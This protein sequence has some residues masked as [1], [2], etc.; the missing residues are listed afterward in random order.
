M[1]RR[2]L[3]T[4]QEEEEDAGDTLSASAAAVPT[5]PTALPTSVVTGAPTAGP[6]AP[7]IPDGSTEI[8]AA[9][10]DGA[11]DDDDGDD[12]VGALQLNAVIAKPR[13]VKDQK[14]RG[15]CDRQC[16]LVVVTEWW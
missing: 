5:G 11:A 8:P 15:R 12:H 16:L 7:T 3:E 4:I 9:A 2:Y 1:W 10:T 6:V 14:V 13:M